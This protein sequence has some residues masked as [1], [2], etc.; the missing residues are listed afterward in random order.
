M[1][2]EM[3]NKK[4]DG[5]CCPKCGKIIKEII[6]LQRRIREK[7]LNKKKKSIKEKK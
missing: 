7:F 4:E 3:K 1:K 2:K 5:I 6:E